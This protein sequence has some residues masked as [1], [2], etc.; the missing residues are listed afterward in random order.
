[1]ELNSITNIKINFHNLFYKLKN[2]SLPANLFSLFIECFLLFYNLFR[3]NFI[4]VG[5]LNKIYPF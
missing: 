2:I 3:I 1:M 4:F 5:N